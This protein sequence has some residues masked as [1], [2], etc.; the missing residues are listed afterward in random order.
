[1]TS[2]TFSAEQVRSAPPEVRRWIENEIAQA[3]AI[4][5]RPRHDP[6]QLQGASLAACASE[7]AMR[8]FELIKANFVLTQVF[9]ELARETTIAPRMSPLYPLNIA[10]ILRHTRLAGGDALADCLSTINQAFRQVRND[11][12]AS[13]F[14]FDDQG[15]VYIHEMTH[16][17]IRRIWEQLVRAHSEPVASQSWEAPTIGFA[18][19][20]VGPSEEIAGHT[21]ERPHRPDLPA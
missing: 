20:Y 17:S 21:G 4:I 7:E 8:L 3:I 16:L 14:G 10:D 15:H 6:S 9:F 2:F 5:G 12:D 11:P 19:P 18:P 1:V 13:L